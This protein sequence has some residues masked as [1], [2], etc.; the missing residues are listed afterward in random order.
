MCRK[1]WAPGQTP[2]LP[3]TLTFTV[4]FLERD[5]TPE[6]AAEQPEG[7]WGAGFCA[8]TTAFHYDTRSQIATVSAGGWS[9]NARIMTRLGLLL[10]P[11]DLHVGAVLSVL[12]RQVTLVSANLAVCWAGAGAACTNFEGNNSNYVLNC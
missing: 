4:R 10:E 2:G 7:K 11:W 5:S 3:P 6:L 12:G 1:T 8:H 9:V